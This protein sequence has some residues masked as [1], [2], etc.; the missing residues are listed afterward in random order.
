MSTIASSV[1]DGPL[2]ECGTWS[3]AVISSLG[4]RARG[5]G[6]QAPM[7]QCRTLSDP[8]RGQASWVELGPVGS[9]QGTSGSRMVPYRSVYRLYT[10][11]GQSSDPSGLV[12]SLRAVS[13]SDGFP[14]EPCF[15]TTGPDEA[16]RIAR[17]SRIGARLM[18]GP[19]RDLRFWRPH[20]PSVGPSGPDRPPADRR[21][22]RRTP[23]NRSAPEACQDH[24]AQA[25]AR[26]LAHACSGS[27]SVLVR[28]C[29]VSGSALVHACSG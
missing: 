7:F 29:S 8:V 20:G 25:S 9:R 1:G 28:A 16:R 2:S 27:G 22:H 14:S 5:G 4:A 23:F 3:H 18:Y 26:A 15:G 6:G 21:R 13:G 11:T 19:I 17:L 10:D 12:G 24:V